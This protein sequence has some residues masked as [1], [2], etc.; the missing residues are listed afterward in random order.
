MSDVARS[1]WI[2]EIILRLLYAVDGAGMRL[3]MTWSQVK[4][5]FFRR[6][7]EASDAELRRALND[8]VDDELIVREWD[9][10][11]RCD[12]FKMASRGRNFVEA[13]YPWGRIDEF[14]GNRTG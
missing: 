7:H 1:R 5:G 8:M 14:T 2:R 13:D 3:G 11:L 4:A 10:D 6:Q 9:E 12:M